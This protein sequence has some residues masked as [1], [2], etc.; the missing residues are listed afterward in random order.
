MKISVPLQAI[1]VHHGGQLDTFN[2]PH[3]ESIF[4]KCCG[5]QSELLPRSGIISEVR[6]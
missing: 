6:N 1:I 4:N 5:N 3:D 2:L